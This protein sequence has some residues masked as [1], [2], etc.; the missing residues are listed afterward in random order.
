[1]VDIQT[2]QANEMSEA[3]QTHRQ[4]M[5]EI[6]VQSDRNLLKL[7]EN[8]K[9]VKDQIR[10]R[11]ETKWTALTGRW[12]DGMQ[13]VS[14]ELAAVNR[15]VDEIGPAWDDPSWPDRPLARQVPPVIRMGSAAVDL[16]AL[17]GGVS[18]DPR[19]MEGLTR[20]F[21]LP[22]L[23]PFPAAANLLIETP[24]EGRAAALEVLQAS[25]FRLLT[26]LPPGMV[27]FTIIDPIGIGRNFGAFMHL[28]D[29]RSGPGH[30]PDLDRFPPDRG[31]AGRAGKLTWRP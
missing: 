16:S 14:S 29:Y 4:R 30:Q 10:T 5:V 15:A 8:Y 19:L 3:V 7:D 6:Q 2:T 26:S 25:M 1:M 9:T 28:A 21:A 27:R 31:A 22:A 23:R 12:R 11:N 13:R 18:S 17:P 24:T 20:R